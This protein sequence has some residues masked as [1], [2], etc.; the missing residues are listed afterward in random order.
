MLGISSDCLA[1]HFIH[2]FIPTDLN[3]FWV[4]ISGNF[5]F[6][7]CRLR[8]LHDDVIKWKHFPRYWPFVR[9]IHRSPLNSSHKGQWRGTLMFSL[10]CTW[11][12]D[13]VNDRDAVD[14]RRHR[15]RYDVTV[16][17]IHKSKRQIQIETHPDWPFSC[18]VLEYSWIFWD[19]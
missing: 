10:I 9:G 19:L 18:Y 15:A 8:R 17:V 4:V 7:L 3:V 11:T 14:L 2:S 16:M 5:S 6:M 13:S 12:D 1:I